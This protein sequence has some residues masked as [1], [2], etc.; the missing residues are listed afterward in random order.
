MVSHISSIHDIMR[1]SGLPTTDKLTQRKELT[2]TFMS[3]A[4]AGD[5]NFHQSFIQKLTPVKEH[6]YFLYTVQQRK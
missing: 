1:K 6:N 2:S 5:P 4:K 3:K